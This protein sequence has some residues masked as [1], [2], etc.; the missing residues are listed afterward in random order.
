MQR[1][2]VSPSYVAAELQARDHWDNH[3]FSE[4]AK[5]SRRAAEI[6]LNDGD[7]ESWWNMT[8]FQAE[9]LL[10]AGWFEECAGVAAALVSEPSA[11]GAQLQSRVRILLSKAWQGAGLLEK[12]AEEA[13]AATKLSADDADAEINV[14]ARLALIAALGES[15]ELDE[16]WTESLNL[17]NAVS[18]EVDDQLLGNAYWVIGNAAFLSNRVDEGLRYHE[19]AAGTFSPARNLEVW[20]RFNSAS[21]A[22]RLAADVADA[23][24][25]RCIERAELATDVIGGSEKY[26]LLQKLNRGHW[27]YLAGDPATAVELLADLRSGA[28]I[29]PPHVLGEA[30][31]LLGR[32]QHSLG[33]AA[34]AKIN[35]AEAA[36]YFETAGAQQ[37]ADH[38]RRVLTAWG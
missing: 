4:A 18:D 23:A 37:R 15:G 9:S 10:A 33:D 31:L 8:F 17:A 21:A 26:I 5:S 1:N 12:A 28:D 16:A 24:T 11:G 36:D 22:M 6:A 25:L 38:T 20:A 7:A 14:T 3:G 35:L 34:A 27:N 19:L 2:S 29:L 30:C 13:R 32:A